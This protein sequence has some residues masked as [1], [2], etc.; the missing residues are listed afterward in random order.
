M[1]AIYNT[2][3]ILLWVNNEAELQH[4]KIVRKSLASCYTRGLC[5][6]KRGSVLRLFIM[7]M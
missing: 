4:I 6:R 2:P 5:P 3:G 1:I 7:D